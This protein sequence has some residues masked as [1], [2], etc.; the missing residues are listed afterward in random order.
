MDTIYRDS[1]RSIEAFPV[2]IPL[3]ELELETFVLHTSSL[4]HFIRLLNVSPTVSVSC[5]MG[6]SSNFLPFCIKSC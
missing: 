3:V 6:N 4:S 1:D 5:K 2:G